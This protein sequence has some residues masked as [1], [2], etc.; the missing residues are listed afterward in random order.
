[1]ACSCSYFI[2]FAVVIVIIVLFCWINYSSIWASYNLYSCW[3]DAGEPYFPLKSPASSNSLESNC[4]QRKRANSIKSGAKARSV[5][6]P[7]S[8]SE[9][10]KK[11][12][13]IVNEIGKLHLPW[14]GKKQKIWNK[15]WC[16]GNVS[17]WQVVLTIS[18]WSL[19]F[20]YFWSSTFQIQT[21]RI[22]AVFVLRIKYTTAPSC[23]G[24]SYSSQ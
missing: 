1:M 2:L 10:G 8:V 4:W 5:P 3:E 15:Y 14:I 11:H 22:I 21:T 6:Y 23:V 16:E 24:K 12:P 18:I 19:H 7:P 17:R 9:Q 13:I 20:R